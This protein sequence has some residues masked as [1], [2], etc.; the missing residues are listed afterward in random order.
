MFKSYTHPYMVILPG[1][2]RLVVEICKT[3]L[4]SVIIVCVHLTCV[5]LKPTNN[6]QTARYASSL[7][8]SSMY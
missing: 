6:K 3:G 7:W 4:K 2:E 1:S 5:S 8:S